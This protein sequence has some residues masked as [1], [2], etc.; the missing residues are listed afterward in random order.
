ML[1]NGDGKSEGSWVWWRKISLLVMILSSIYS[2]KLINSLL[3]RAEF[4][5]IP[6]TVGL[7]GMGTHLPPNCVNPRIFHVIMLLIAGGKIILHARVGHAVCCN[8]TNV[9]NSDCWTGKLKL[10]ME[11]SATVWKCRENLQLSLIVSKGKKQKSHNFKLKK[12]KSQDTLS[13]L[14]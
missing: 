11:L 10:E 4:R 2:G 1:E 13:Y 6:L 5:S 3:L 9:L 7:C 12:E 14:L 8:L